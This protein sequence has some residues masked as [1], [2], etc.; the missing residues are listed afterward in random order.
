MFGRPEW[1]SI[2]ESL[3]LKNDVDAPTLL[4]CARSVDQAAN[5]QRLDRAPVAV[6]MEAMSHGASLL[7]THFVKNCNQIATETGFCQQLSDLRFVPVVPH[8]QQPSGNPSLDFHDEEVEADV[9]H[10]LVSYAE[11]AVPRDWAL[12]WTKQPVCPVEFLPPQP[13]WSRLR[14]QTPPSVE[15]VVAHI[16]AIPHDVLERWAFAESQEKTFGRI[17]EFLE[18]RLDELPLP[19]LKELACVPVCN[20]LVKPSRLFFHLP[21]ELAPFLFEVPR[22]YGIHDKLFRAIGVRETSSD[23]TPL[24]SLLKDLGAEFAG[25]QLNPSESATV[26]RTLQ[27]LADTSESTFDI[28]S[29]H[30]IFVPAA[31]H[32]L[33]CVTRDSN[34]TYHPS[35]FV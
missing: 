10:L 4:A 16:A 6:D 14:I 27:M 8:G 7:A 17:F 35:C 11:I 15:A 1:I 5:A 18:D 22:G 28:Q 23:A 24:L 31:D 3:D 12:V 25:R 21:Y 13:F 30:E 33:R 19:Q 20:N 9:G 29:S 2:L 26:R 32:T 34:S